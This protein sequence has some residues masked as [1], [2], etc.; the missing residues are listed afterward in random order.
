M[1]TT[2]KGA[3][4][5]RHESNRRHQ[6]RTP[7]PPKDG[8]Q[9]A[10]PAEV[11][12][13]DKLR[14][15]AVKLPRKSAAKVDPEELRTATRAAREAQR[16]APAAKA[17]A[18]KPSVAEKSADAK[19]AATRRPAK[20]AS[21]SSTSVPPDAPGAVKAQRL[22]DAAREA[23]WTPK[24]VIKGTTITVFSEREGESIETTLTDGKLDLSAMPV[25]TDG[26]RTVKLKNV[27]AVIAQMSGT[28]PTAKAISATPRAPRRTKAQRAEESPRPLPFDPE[29]ASDEEVLDAIRGRA[30]E[31]M[32]GISR[33]VEASVVAAT[34]QVKNPKYKKGQST[35]EP[36]YIDR[37]APVKIEEHPNR[38]TRV[39]TFTDHGGTGF[40]SVALDRLTSVR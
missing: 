12:T 34:I 1:T 25:W 9:N 32:N 2:V 22:V 23:G 16:K 20:K 29:G 3:G 6:Q 35:G 40:R 4:R 11:E 15:A 31:W 8:S 27:S 37:P 28:K 17:T 26:S 38:S 10:T 14:A 36:E 13:A 24:F 21:A 5:A 33:K 39:V 30:I 18:A 7:L 19:P